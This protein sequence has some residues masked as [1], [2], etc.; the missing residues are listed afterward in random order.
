MHGLIF[1]TSIWLL[2]GSTRF[3]SYS[4]TALTLPTTTLY[5]SLSELPVIV[6]NRKTKGFTNKQCCFLSFNN[7][8]HH[9]RYGFMTKL[10]VVRNRQRQSPDS[11]QY[12]LPVT[13][14]HTTV[15]VFPFPT[16]KQPL[17]S[18]SSGALAQ[19]SDRWK[20]DTRADPYPYCANKWHI[21]SLHLT[22]APILPSMYAYWYLSGRN[23]HH[24][25]APPSS[26]WRAGL[27]FILPCPTQSNR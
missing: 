1:E 19:L 7:Q 9:V 12:Y 27:E 17:P 25:P 6:A 11:P 8:Q 2:A 4:T 26:Q 15:L 13:F 5:M 24:T 14:I 16:T 21:Y 22:L 20:L 3:L 10:K 18:L 23:L